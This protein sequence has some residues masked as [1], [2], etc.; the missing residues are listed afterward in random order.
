MAL[1]VYWYKST[2]ADVVIVEINSTIRTLPTII[3]SCFGIHISSW[4]IEHV[5]P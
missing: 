4:E 3:V 2:R 5:T 1:A